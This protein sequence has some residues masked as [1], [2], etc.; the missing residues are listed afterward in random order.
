MLLEMLIIDTDTMNQIAKWL[1][2]SHLWG[3]KAIV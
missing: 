1:V 3:S 2:K